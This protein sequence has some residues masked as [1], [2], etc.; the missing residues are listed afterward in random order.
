MIDTSILE[1]ELWLPIKGWNGKY[2]VSN[3]GRIRSVGGKY[4]KSKPDGY[5]TIGFRDITGYRALQLRRPGYTERHRIHTL[6][7]EHFLVKPEWAECVNHLDGNKENNYYLNLEWSTMAD[8]VKHAVRT[9]LFD[10]KG[11]K[12]FNSKL[13]SDKVIEMRRLRKETN[14]THQQIA[15]LFGICRRQAGDVIN[16][17]NWGWL[18][19]GL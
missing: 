13:T 7:A 9:G 3:H 16:G 1:L 4:R 8:N 12:H 17:V 19:E 18:K 6:V 14:M 5:F 10:T 2:F 11:E 15:D